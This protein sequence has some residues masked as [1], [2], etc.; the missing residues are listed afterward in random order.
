MDTSLES[1]SVFRVDVDGPAAVIAVLPGLVGHDSDGKIG[2]RI[3]VACKEPCRVGGLVLIWHI[4]TGDITRPNSSTMWP[5][6]FP[7]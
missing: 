4:D 6:P 2:F 3:G 1:G 7:A 5:R